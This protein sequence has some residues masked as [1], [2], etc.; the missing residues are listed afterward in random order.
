MEA[1]RFADLARHLG[2]AARAHNLTVPAFRSPPRKPGA[3]RTLRRYEGGAVVAVVLRDRADVDVAMDMVEGI[4]ATNAPRFAEADPH[5]TEGIGMEGSAREGMEGAARAWLDPDGEQERRR[6]E[7]AARRE[8]FRA[9]P[10]ADLEKL[11]VEPFGP[12]AESPSPL[13]SGS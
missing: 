9:D 7:E 13:G 3:T 6:T 1:I 8:A 12:P 10:P 11:K 4:L 2:A 5:T